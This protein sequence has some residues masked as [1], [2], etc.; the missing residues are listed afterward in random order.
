MMVPF[1]LRHGTG[2]T[3]N[4]FEKAGRRHD[5]LVNMASG[6]NLQINDIIA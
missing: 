6:G 4:V 3:T 2:T 5:A 1:L